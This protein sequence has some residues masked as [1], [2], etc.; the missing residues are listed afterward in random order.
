MLATLATSKTMRQW[1]LSIIY[2]INLNARQIR[3]EQRGAN[4]L[5]EH[6]IIYTVCSFDAYF[7]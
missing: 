3:R 7:M 1:I 6:R 2:A 5:L 4:D